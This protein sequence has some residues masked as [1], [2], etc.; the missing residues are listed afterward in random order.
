MAQDT[1]AKDPMAVEFGR[2]GG[3]ARLTSMT[4]EERRRIARLAAR[5]RWGKKAETPTPPPSGPNG[6]LLATLGGAVE[7]LADGS[8]AD[9]SRYSVKSDGE[10]K[11]PQIVSVSGG[12]S[13]KAA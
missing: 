9:H 5:A 8:T 7:Y 13:G 3:K 12:A 2:R 11:P 1:V 10:R 6:G 4:A